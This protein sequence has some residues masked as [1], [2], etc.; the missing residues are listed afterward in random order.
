MLR[1]KQ[2]MSL[3]VEGNMPVIKVDQRGSFFFC[4]KV[5]I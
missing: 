1:V 5:N 4:F 3:K 2:V